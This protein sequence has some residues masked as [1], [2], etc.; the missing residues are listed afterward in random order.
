[1][2][3]YRRYLAPGSR[4]FFTVVTDHRRRFL[5][6]PVARS[7]LREAF[8]VVRARHPFQA[9]ALVLLPDHLH[10]IWNLPEGDAN[11]A[12]RWR[13]I[14]E[15]FT[16]KYL[17]AGGLEGERSASRVRRVEEGG[18]QR[19]G[20]AEPKAAAQNYSRDPPLTTPNNHMQTRPPRV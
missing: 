3:N 2:P 10:A 15:E 9:P 12:M 14:K 13:R 17:A 16:E 1:M 8:Q 7:C 11:Y 6:D 4:V 18:W 19:R 20:S 5:I